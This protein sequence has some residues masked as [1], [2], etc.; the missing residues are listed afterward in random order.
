MFSSSY[1]AQ[2]SEALHPQ[3]HTTGLT[4][5]IS[6][7]VHIG[8]VCP[9]SF[10][11][12][13]EFKLALPFSFTHSPTLTQS[14]SACCGLCTCLAYFPALHKSNDNRSR[15]GYC[16]HTTC[17]PLPSATPLCLPHASGLL[18]ECHEFSD[19]NKT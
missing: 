4:D 14:R 12:F 16:T 17:P 2:C 9:A 6:G 7:Q 19:A 10:N 11:S 18:L 15:R 13:S 3:T 1:T 5:F 8:A